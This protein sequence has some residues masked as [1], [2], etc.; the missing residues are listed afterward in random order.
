M[1]SNEP[2][3]SKLFAAILSGYA[4]PPAIMVLAAWF[5]LLSG[6]DYRTGGNWAASNIPAL[7]AMHEFVHNEARAGIGFRGTCD[8]IPQSAGSTSD[9]ASDS[10]SEI[11]LASKSECEMPSELDMSHF[12]VAAAP[13]T[14]DFSA[15]GRAAAG[16][17]LEDAAVA[18]APLPFDPLEEL[19][20]AEAAEFAQS[21]VGL[22]PMEPIEAAQT[23]AAET[24]VEMT[25][26]L[27]AVA[28]AEQASLGESFH[29]FLDHD[30]DANNEIRQITHHIKSGET[31]SHVLGKAGLDRDAIREWV[32]AAHKLYN[33]NRVYVGQEISLRINGSDN[34]LVRLSFETG[35]TSVLIAERDQSGIHAE[36]REIPH[37]RRLRVAGGEIRSSLYMAAIERGIPDPIVSDIAEILGWEINFAKDLQP[38][39]TFRVVFEE[40]VRTDTDAAMPGRI[41]AVD[42]TN[43]GQSH[44]GFYFITPD[45]GRGG[46]YNRNGDALG[47]AFLRYPVEYS[48]IS[49]HFSDARYHP[50][51]KRSVPHYGVDF[52]APTG[53]PVHAVADGTVVMARWHRGNGRFVKLRHD[54]VYESGYAHLSRIATGLTPDMR[55]RKGEVIGYVGMT[56]LATGP[57]LHFAMYR[58]GKYIDPLTSSL[59]RANSLAGSTLAAYEMS[60]GMIDHAYM[61]AGF[62]TDVLAQAARNEATTSP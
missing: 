60:L 46:Y 18:N 16:W 37:Y 21:H 9:T 2:P 30:T 7:V 13:M 32:Q 43:R 58:S 49:S 11:R 5:T 53:T 42:V 48:R 52:A 34:S 26:D 29:H 56:G 3:S 61:Q 54:T 41:L 15:M 24:A 17:Q 40:L 23:E 55:V 51:L 1:N 47:R 38:G 59:P 44:E 25:L 36:L 27:Q 57:H 50:I 14:Y 31:I 22:L 6:A 33:L 45:G 12:L 62:S 19:R 4:S 8:T 35:R 20:A 39:A 28:N 10:M